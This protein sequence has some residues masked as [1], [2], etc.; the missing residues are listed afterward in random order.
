MR[1]IAV[2]LVFFLVLIVGCLGS[3][4]TEKQFNTSARIQA[5]GYFGDNGLT[6][7]ILA[8]SLIFKK[9]NQSGTL[10]APSYV[11]TQ[12]IAVELLSGMK[13]FPGFQYRY[14]Q[15]AGIRERSENNSSVL[16]VTV[17]IRTEE[18]DKNSQNNSAEEYDQYIA[19]FRKEA[20]R[21]RYEKEY[22]KN[23]GRRSVPD[24]I[25]KQA[26]ELSLTCQS[27]RDYLERTGKLNFPY[28]SYSYYWYF[29][30][31]KDYSKG[32]NEPAD[33]VVNITVGY[34]EYGNKPTIPQT[35]F[36][37]SITVNI[38]QQKVY[39]ASTEA[40]NP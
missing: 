4:E 22:A 2:I 30:S 17:L 11:D 40:C 29:G 13:P 6:K 37:I 27:V 1:P 9:E 25:K 32:I 14:F 31:E 28:N 39:F 23:Q 33:A 3:I 16:D 8:E 36:P 7:E 18:E 12:Q 19:R 26:F 15:A 34:T 10:P 38:T 35:I 5:N 20:G 24:S 21:T